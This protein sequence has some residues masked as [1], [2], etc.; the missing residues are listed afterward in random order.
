M[1]DF[2]GLQEI[3]SFFATPSA[4]LLLNEPQ[5]LM[6]E[7]SGVPTYVET[8]RQALNAIADDLLRNGIRQVVVPGYLCESMLDPFLYNRF[9]V[10]FLRMT[11]DLQIDLNDLER[12]DERALGG[13][14][15]VL[16][17]RYFGHER[18]LRYTVAISRL[19]DFGVPVIEDLS[20]SL[21][22]ETASYADYTF[23]SLRK[24]LPIASG[25]V[26]TG[27]D[28]LASLNPSRD[29]VM[30]HVWGSMDAKKGYMEG[31]NPDRSFYPEFI[32]ANRT[33]E[34]T[35]DPHMIDGRSLSLL[36]LLPYSSLIDSRRRNYA[37]LLSRLADSHVVQVVNGTHMAT[38]SH[39]LIRTPNSTFVRQKLADA[40][41]YCPV[42]WPRPRG[43]PATAA[44]GSDHFS[45]P[46]DHR[47]NEEALEYVADC[48]KEICK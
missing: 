27:V 23:A 10:H 31:L 33:L 16:M 36:P 40:R 5:P 25:A 35:L 26:L 48:V 17:A 8:G 18:D 29:S 42:H 37:F 12:L 44:W 2:S 46:I 20:H 9:D 28:S 22:D 15:A 30:D 19:Q 1:K 7:R 6:W 13:R 47:Y 43:V 32:A 45:I 3:G 11:D 34:E 24:L 14:Y 41:I 39:L 38:A 4:D 21:F